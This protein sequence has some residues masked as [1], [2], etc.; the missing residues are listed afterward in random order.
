[1]EK[2]KQL[3]DLSIEELE[4]NYRDA[5]SALF[6]LINERGVSKSFEKPHRIPA[7]KRQIAR[8]L[9]IISEKQSVNS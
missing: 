4:A 5:Q 7:T 9:T 2:A 3:R 6:H 8:L 1:M